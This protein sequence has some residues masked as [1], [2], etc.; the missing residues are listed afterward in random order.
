MNDSL[1]FAL[2]DPLEIWK[3]P[4]AN[5]VCQRPKDCLHVPAKVRPLDEVE[6]P[7]VE[8]EKG[9]DGTR[10]IASKHSC[11]CS[12]KN[13]GGQSSASMAK[14]P[15]CLTEGETPRVQQVD[16]VYTKSSKA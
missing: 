7:G 16:F 13:V 8:T 12:N 11:R 9:I 14:L 2:N 4:S 10:G 5:P 1:S 6:C 3:R 15:E